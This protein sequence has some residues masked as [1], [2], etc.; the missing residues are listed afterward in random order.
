MT[1]LRACLAA[2][3]E[4]RECMRVLAKSGD[5]IVG[6]L[7]READSFFE[8]DHNP[9]GDVY[10]PVTRSQYYYHA[11]PESEERGE[12]GHFHTFLRGAGMPAGVQPATSRH[13]KPPPGDESLC[14]LIAI[15]MDHYG[16]PQA[17]F[18]TNRWVTGEVWYA[19]EDVVSMLD[20]FAID[21][22]RPSWPV[23]RW[24]TAMLLLFR[25]QIEN[26]VRARDRQVAAWAREHPGRNP[27]DDTALEITSRLPISIDDQMEAVRAALPRRR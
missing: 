16:N 21:L 11:H 4:A 2:G 1:Q 19:A 6:E 14:H 13:L 20:R 5:N 26:L 9:K 8:W 18:T 3:E 22:A 10:D 12:H 25:P 27:Y 17:L 15:S 7:L 24:I 23:N